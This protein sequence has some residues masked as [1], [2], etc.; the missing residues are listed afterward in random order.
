MVRNNPAIKSYI[1][2]RFSRN[3]S[4]GAVHDR[5]LP[6]SQSWDQPLF[7][8]HRWW[9]WWPMGPCPKWGYADSP[10][11]VLLPFSWK[12]RNVLN[13]M[14]NQYLFFDLSWKMVVFSTKV[15][16][17]Q[18]ICFFLSIQHIPHLSC[19]FAH[20]WKQNLIP[21]QNTEET[22]AKYAFDINLFQ[23]GSTNLKKESPAPGYFLLLK[24]F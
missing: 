12:M 18:K 14:K 4:L 3:F 21:M 6:S 11:S 15:T 20:F 5:V 24:F 2:T 7:I 13:Q 10:T 22:I 19:K 17:T 1:A 8:L 9:H 16:I 23:L